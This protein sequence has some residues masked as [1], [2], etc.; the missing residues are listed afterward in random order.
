MNRTE[1]IRLAAEREAEPFARAILRARQLARPSYLLR[2]GRLEL[3]DDGLDPASRELVAECEAAIN[4]IH[5]RA[6]E[7]SHP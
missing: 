5:A 2:D 1:Q 6:L 3:L 4:D 7:L